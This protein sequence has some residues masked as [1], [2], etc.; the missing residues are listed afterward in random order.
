MVQDLEQLLNVHGMSSLGA[1][2]VLQNLHA[3]VSAAESALPRLQPA[4]YRSRVQ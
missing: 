2:A 1:G 3:L 4:T